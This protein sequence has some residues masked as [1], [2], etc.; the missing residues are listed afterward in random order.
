MEGLVSRRSLS[1]RGSEGPCRVLSQ[2]GTFRMKGPLSLSQ[3]STPSCTIFPRG[4]PCLMEGWTLPHGGCQCPVS[5]MTPSHMRSS[6]IAPGKPILMM[7]A[8]RIFPYGGPCIVEG[9]A[10][11]KI[12]DRLQV[13]FPNSETL[14]FLKN[15]CASKKNKR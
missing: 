11:M 9:S 6:V 14:Y 10:S 13:C 12:Q 1:Q 7:F 2:D 5:R 3:E 8:R 15:N 4:G